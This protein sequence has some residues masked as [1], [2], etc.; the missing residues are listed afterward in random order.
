MARGKK[1]LSDSVSL[2]GRAGQGL[3]AD[4]AD[5]R[6]G[7]PGNLHILSIKAL[8]RRARDVRSWLGQCCLPLWAEAGL[9]R[10]QGF[11]AR[12][13][14]NHRAVEEPVLAD[15]LG[16]AAMADLFSLSARVGFDTERGAD[17][18]TLAKRQLTGS[19]PPEPGAA[20]A[21]A[22]QRTMAGQCALLRAHLMALAGNDAAA[23]DAVLAFDT[24][25]DDFLTPQGGW[26]AGF[27]DDGRADPPGIPTYLGRDLARAAA[28]LL[29]LIEA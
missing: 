16:H 25:M 6:S 13:E 18:V 19:P 9:V 3:Q 27:A 11:V 21:H 23:A 29:D 20:R 1:S 28:P 17:L 8:K 22:G 10:G 2:H 14:D 26:I 7:A 24:L 15:A 4:L 12:L 5:F